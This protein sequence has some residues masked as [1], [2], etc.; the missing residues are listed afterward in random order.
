MR[1]AQSGAS[2]LIPVL[3]LITVAAFGAIVA[4]RQSGSD[5]QNTDA[6]A[7]SVEALY[8]AET[9]VERALKRYATG[10]ACG[11]ALGETI[12]N[13]ASIGGATGR[14]ITVG[15]GLTT[16]F[17]GAALAPN[18][19]CRIPVTASITASA[20]S[21][22]IHVIVDRNLL[23][24]A[25]NPTFDNPSAGATPSGWSG[26]DPPGPPP[27]A[28]AA[29]GGPDGTA[30]ACTR[31]AWLAR[32]NPGSGATD[33]RATAIAAVSFTLTAGSV[34][35][36]FFNRRVVSRPS[37]CGALPPAGPA[38]LPATCAAANDST[39]CLQFNGTGGAGTWAVGSSA[40]TAGAGIAACP[41][42]F[43]P[44]QT[45]YQAGAPATKV[46]MN[47]TMTGATSVNQIVYWLQLQNAGRKELFVD[48][49]EATN[50]SAVGAAQV[51]LWRDCSTV[52]NP[53]AC[54]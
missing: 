41:S 37:D 20:V 34:T 42:T 19:R 23:S 11:A 3:L 24:R 10:T 29:N 1:P 26:F 45:S 53:A 13:L 44:C 7:D 35:N 16:D 30:P 6:L 27:P 32:D 2:L 22:T 31:S 25:D 4:A 52:A 17:S 43:N 46:A 48:G 38:A 12:T 39:V 9:G 49:L 28:F 8:L 54:T 51:I 33:R 50:T 5:I 40:A 14:S 15:T 36:I 18:T 47:V 21:R